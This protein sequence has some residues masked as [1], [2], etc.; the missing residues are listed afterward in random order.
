MGNRLE[1]VR[2]PFVTHAFAAI[3]GGSTVSARPTAVDDVHQRT[4]AIRFLPSLPPHCLMAMRASP[5]AAAGRSS[6]LSDPMRLRRRNAADRRMHSPSLPRALCA[7]GLRA[8]ALD[9]QR[10]A[11]AYLRA[12]GL[13]Q[14]PVRNIRGPP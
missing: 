1:V 10:K 13:R 14:K 8:C 3:F 9:G 6:T 7:P 4:P 11:A 2:G 12:N 5:L